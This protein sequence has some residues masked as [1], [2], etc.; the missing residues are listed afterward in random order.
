MKRRLLLLLEAASKLN[1]D[2]T[3]RRRGSMFILLGF[4]GSP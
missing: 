2:Q 1:L 4:E 3:H